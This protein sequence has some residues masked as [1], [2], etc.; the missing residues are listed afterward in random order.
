M[1]SLLLLG[2][3]LGMLLG[4]D[5]A[6]AGGVAFAQSV[7]LLIVAARWHHTGGTSKRRA[8]WTVALVAVTSV[9]TTAWLLA[10]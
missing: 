4:L 7:V 5:A 9:A 6:G 1:A 3:G 8:S 10:R 2:C